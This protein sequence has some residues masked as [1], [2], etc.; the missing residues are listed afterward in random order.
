MPLGNLGPGKATNGNDPRARRPAVS[1]GH[2][3]RCRSGSTDISFASARKGNGRPWFA[4]TCHRRHT[5][6]RAMSSTITAARRHR[7]IFL[8]TTILA[9]NAT[10]ALAQNVASNE[11]PP[12]DVSPSTDPNKTRARPLT[13]EGGGVPRPVRSTTPS[14]GTGTG[15]SD[16]ST[17]SGTGAGSGTGVRQFNGI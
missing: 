17:G 12:V 1:R 11:L 6:V 4:V 16:A 13:D 3:R 8:A 2:T 14:R 9:L 7:A 10:L 15:T 5:E